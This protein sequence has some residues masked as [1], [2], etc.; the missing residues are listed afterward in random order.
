MNAVS[1]AKSNLKKQ[2]NIYSID[3]LVQ[4]G[5]LFHSTDITYTIDR[6]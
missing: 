4:V 2:N 1:Y 5:P 6:F 3:L